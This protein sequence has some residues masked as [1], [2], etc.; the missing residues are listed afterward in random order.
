MTDFSE[1]SEEDKAVIA[2]EIGGA[3]TMGAVIGSFVPVLGS[4]IGAGFGAI[5]GG[6]GAINA[7]VG[8]DGDDSR[9]DD[10]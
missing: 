2:E 8:K 3:I 10:N 9:L 6:I 5:V 1:V 4:L 7:A